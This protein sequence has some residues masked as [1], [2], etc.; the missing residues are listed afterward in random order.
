VAVVI[1]PGDIQARFDRD[2]LI[3]VVINLLSNAAKFSD[4]NNPKVWVS[5]E[6]TA[7]EAL[8]TVRDNGPGVPVERHDV[9]F[10]KFQQ[11]MDDEAGRP[12]GTGLGLP[13]SREIITYMDGRLWVEAGPGSG[14]VFRFAL[15]LAAPVT[16]A[17]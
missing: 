5:L 10:E 6:R 17:T 7:H 13:I 2:R 15:P 14:A 9:I 16:V 11:V 3:Q 12:I 4:Q 8:V 1:E